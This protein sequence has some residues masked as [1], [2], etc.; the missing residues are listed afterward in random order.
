MT[1]SKRLPV[2]LEVRDLRM[3]AAVAAEGSLTQAGARLHVTQPALSRHLAT[4]ERRVGSTLFT[5]TGPR[6]QP[7][8]AGELLLRHA[9][10]VLERVAAT[11]CALRDFQHAPRRTLRIGTSC[12]TGYH[13]MPGVLNRYT[14]RHPEV[15][16]EIAFEA[17]G[18]PVRRLRAG[19]L[20]VA[21]V[22]DGGTYRGYSVRRL[23]MDEYIAVVAPGHRLS[24]RAYIDAK[25][26]LT[27]RVLLMSDPA[28]SNIVNQ[29]I[30][31]AGVKPKFIADVQLVGAVAALAESGF[32][33][34]MVPNWTI[35]PEVRS[36]RLVSLRLGPTGFI[37]A[38]AAVMTR[39]QARE[40][41][42]QEFVHAIAADAPSLGL[43]PAE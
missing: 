21:L 3:M 17:A 28:T 7:T 32:G 35:A 12:Y 1:P 29:F 34:G 6:M 39:E 8:A 14:A 10:D 19:A 31:P 24:N 25:D 33:I 5:R 9:A 16:I 27:E 36:K 18:D 38:W 13:W 30:K 23:F 15:D 22:T 26:L 42:L 11:E 41:W 43:Q 40:R 20:E 4:L 37:R 2:G